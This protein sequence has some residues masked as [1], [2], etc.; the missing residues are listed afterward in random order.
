[1]TTKTRLT[2]RQRL[3]RGLSYTAVGPVDITRGTLGLGVQGVHSAGSGLRRR[4]SKRVAKGLSAAQAS[5]TRD[6]STAQQSLTRDLSAAQEVAAGL[7]HAFQK[8]R[9]H[10]QRRRIIIFSAAGLLTVA[11]GAVAFT[12]IRRSSAPEPS[13]RPPSVDV[14]PKP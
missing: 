2:P 7:P 10:R 3:T 11:G 8:R 1:M 5:V 14:T 13:P 12:L 9:H 4:Y 6:L